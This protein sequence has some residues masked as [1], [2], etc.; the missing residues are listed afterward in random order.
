MKKSIIISVVALLI[1]VVSFAQNNEHKAIERKA[2]TVEQIAKRNAE[3]QRKT[4]ALND[5]QYQKIYKLYLKQAKK[6][7]AQMEQMKKEREKMNSQLKKIFTQEQ[8]AKYEKMQKRAKFGWKK[9]MQ[10][11]AKPGQHPTITGSLEKPQR[12]LKIE[13]PESRR[14]NMYIEK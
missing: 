10:R 11:P 2:P 9:P 4:L 3:R 7:Q 6:Q 14:T 13:K 8:W 12:R 5:A 1:S